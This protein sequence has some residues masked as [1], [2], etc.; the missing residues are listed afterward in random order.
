M[1]LMEVLELPQER[2]Q[3][4][5]NEAERQRWLNAAVIARGM[6]DKSFSRDY[7]KILTVHGGYTEGFYENQLNALKEKLQGR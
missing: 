3:I 1:P 7:H 2:L 5:Y 4:L 6:G